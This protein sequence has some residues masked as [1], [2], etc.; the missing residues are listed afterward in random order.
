MTRTGGAYSPIELSGAAIA[1]RIR[2]GEL[3]VAEAVGAFTDRV[4]ER[5]PDV[6]AWVDWDPD[7]ALAEARSR[8]AEPPRGPLHGVPIGIKD[9]VDTSDRPTQHGS[10]IFR[11]H[12]PAADAACVALLRAA[13]AVVMG[14]TTTTEL[15]AYEPSPTRN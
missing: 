14:K 13:G 2:A 12:R 9:I 1:G 10:R 3:S 4:A 7:P 6:R 11:G 8:D 15:A 5:E